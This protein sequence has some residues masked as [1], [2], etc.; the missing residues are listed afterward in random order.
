MPRNWLDSVG[1]LV[2]S[3][4]LGQGPVGALR[5]PVWRCVRVAAVV[6]TLGCEAEPAILEAH[7]AP[8]AYHEVV[9]ERDVE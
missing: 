7:V 8:A 6:A 2:P 1:V 5:D 9:P 4:R 3:E